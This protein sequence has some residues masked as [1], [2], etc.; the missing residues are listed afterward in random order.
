MVESILA[1]I[2]AA[3]RRRL[4][5][6]KQS[7]PPSQM[8][9]MAGETT[10]AFGRE[11]GAHFETAL[12][13]PG[14][15]FICEVK[16]ASPSKG[17][18]AADFPYVAIAREYEAAGAAAISVLTEPDF[19]QG[20][21]R[22]LGEIARAVDLPVLRKDFIVDPYQLHQ[23]RVLGAAAVLLITSLLGD[24]LADYLIVAHKLGLAGLVEVHDEAETKLAVDAGARIIG[25]NH[26]DLRTFDVDL[27][28]SE[29][30]RRL[31]PEDTVMV[32]E[33]GIKTADDVRRL[34][35][36]GVAAVLVG[37]T[38]MRA[39]DKAAALRA[40]AGA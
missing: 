40:L 6:E 4:V 13:V 33:S 20:D 17:L 2:V 12:R 19:F 24:H 29:R 39:S 22:Y 18:I 32:A 1:D 35:D 27:S 21:K 28:L 38:L 26:R 11:G 9:L 25:V 36:L 37:E 15:A 14:V 3:T 7:I 23:A 10:L 34:A 16:K 8:W 31:I 30:L 5:D